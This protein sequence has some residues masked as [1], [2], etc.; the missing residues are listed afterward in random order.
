MRLFSVIGYA[1]LKVMISEDGNRE[2]GFELAKKRL[3]AT[4]AYSKQTLDSY[5]GHIA[6]FIEFLYAA[7]LVGWK[8]GVTV[9]LILNTYEEYLIAPLT[10]SDDFAYQIA[11]RTGRTDSCG[12]GSL[13]VIESAL[14]AFLKGSSEVLAKGIDD[15]VF[16]AYVQEIIIIDGISESRQLRASRKFT[17]YISDTPSKRKRKKNRLFSRTKIRR[18]G[19]P[20]PIRDDQHF[21]FDKIE[22]LI[23][24]GETSRD[25]AL[26]ALLAALGC[27]EHEALQI[28]LKDIKFLKREIYLVDPHTRHCA[29]ITEDEARRLNW[30]G[31]STSQ[32]YFLEPWGDIFWAEVSAYM[33]NERIKESS[34]DFLFQTLSGPT[35]GR[36]LFTSDRSSRNKAFHRHAATCGVTLPTGTAIHSLRHS[37]G[38]YALNYHPRRDGSMGFELATVAKMLGHSDIFN[39][40]KYAKKDRSLIVADLQYARERMHMA[41]RSQKQ[42]LISFHR[43]QLRLLQNDQPDQFD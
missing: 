23:Y 6:R 15:C 16:T 10:T 34:H 32:T 5:L 14:T 3:I 38:V 4:K 39:T 31:R 27:R 21:P 37:Y 43:Q 33:K 29:G 19:N 41:D 26:Y 36:P 7:F 25:R 12:I 1:A 2:V 28:R 13:G 40:K 42:I 35:C 17:S 22:Q 20:D 8:K 30:K 24:S 9:D 18:F 11:Q